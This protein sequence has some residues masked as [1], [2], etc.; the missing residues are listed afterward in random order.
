LKLAP[1]DYFYWDKRDTKIIESENGE[2]RLASNIRLNIRRS[3]DT[4]FHLNVKKRAH[5][6]SY[7]DAKD[8]AENI[9]YNFY[10][11]QSS[12]SFDQFFKVPADYPY[13][14]QKV[15]LTLLVPT[16]NSIYLGEQLKYFIYDIRNV[17]RMHNR[18][19]IGNTWKMTRK[20][21]TC[22]SCNNLDTQ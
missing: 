14:Q 11:D 21:L 3:R 22:L 5:A 1:H 7:Y 8:Y 20:G 18:D 6:N 12:L 2:Y 15:K 17:H 4:L 16:D 9:S 13:Q 10:E 19:M